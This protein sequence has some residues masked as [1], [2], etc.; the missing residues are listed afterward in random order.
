MRKW[1]YKTVSESDRLNDE[2]LNK[3]GQEGWELVTIW[4]QGNHL[5]NRNWVFKREIIEPEFVIPGPG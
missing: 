4:R 1:E 2:K 3:L 5:G